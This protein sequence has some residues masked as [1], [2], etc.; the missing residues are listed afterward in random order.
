MADAYDRVLQRAKL[1]LSDEH[2]ASLGE[3]GIETL[4][5]AVMIMAFTDGD[6]C[7]EETRF[8]NDFA[9]FLGSSG[10]DS[11][12]TPEA[13][14]ERLKSFNFGAGAAEAVM[15]ILL[16]VSDLDNNIDE[17]EL[18]FWNDVGQVLNVNEDRRGVIKK[19]LMA[20][21]QTTQRFEKRI[22]D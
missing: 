1:V 13:L 18:N 22:Q 9:K 14:L 6:V 16:M 10:S 8:L 15:K 12:L 7:D 2:R 21:R 3:K 5:D 11:D 19:M 20:A 17:D 4:Y